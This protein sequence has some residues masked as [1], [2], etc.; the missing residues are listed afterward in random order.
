MSKK[1]AGKKRTKIKT[2]TVRNDGGKSLNILFRLERM[3]ENERILPLTLLSGHV[4]PAG[5]SGLLCAWYPSLY[6]GRDYGLGAK[7]CLWRG[8]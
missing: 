4:L 5:L 1:L 8:R 2:R 7:K 3:I 6:P